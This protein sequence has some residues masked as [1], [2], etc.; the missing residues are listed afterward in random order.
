MGDES[1]AIGPGEAVAVPNE[2]R[3]QP[4]LGL[5]LPADTCVLLPTPGA[6]G[7]ECA[8][9]IRD[10]SY[11]GLSFRVTAAT[12]WIEE[13]WVGRARLRFGG[14]VIGGNLLVVHVAADAESGTV[15]GAMFFAASKDDRMTLREVLSE[16]GRS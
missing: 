3:A 6:E 12:P 7:E 13:G 10:I 16:L 14:R 15:C 8:A 9:P 4:R 11:G 1:R 2:R 5:A